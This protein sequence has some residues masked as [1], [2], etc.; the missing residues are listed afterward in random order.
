MA[1]MTRTP[2]E[3]IHV[4]QNIRRYNCCFQMTSFG[5]TSIVKES[6]F[7]PTFKVQGQIYHRIG[8]RLP[9]PNESPKFLQIYFMGEEQPQVDQRCQNIPGT[10]CIII[11][12]LQRLLRGQNQ[13][14]NTFTTALDK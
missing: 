9:C 13:L 1:Y 8:S 3:L 2:A 5:A 7:M 6:G 4:R 14:M 10:R 11:E 12:P